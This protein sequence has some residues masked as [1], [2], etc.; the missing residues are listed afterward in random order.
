MSE[1]SSVQDVVIV[2]AGAAGIG[3]A[4]QA[5]AD[6]LR[7]TVLEAAPRIGG[8]A[9]TDPRP[10]GLP[11]DAGCHW[12]HSA[13]V[14]PFTKLADAYGFRYATG[15]PETRLLLDGV[16]VTDRKAEVDAYEEAAYHAALRAGGNGEDVPVA[17]VVDTSSPYYG[18]FAMSIR[19]EWGASPEET[20]TINVSGYDAAYTG[21]DWPVQDG[22]GA[23]VARHA[24]GIPVELST[25][26]TR[27]E[28]GRTPIRVHTL[29]GVLETRAVVVTVS[30]NVL[31]DEV[32][33]FDPPLPHRKLEALR[34]VPLGRAN[35]VGILVDDGRRLGVDGHGGAL[36]WS[37]SD[38]ARGLAFQLRPFGWDFANAYIAGDLC[39]EL[40]RA[41]EAAMVAYALENLR[42]LLGSDIDR[43]VRATAVTRWESE[44]YI[45]G[46][47]AVAKPGHGHDR[48]VIR[49]PLADRVHFAGEAL[50]EA[51]FSTCHGAYLSGMEAVG[52]AV[53]SMRAI[54]SSG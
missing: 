23:L 36:V 46:A 15:S 28:W 1:G 54:V 50:S 49:E 17:V 21:E 42:A 22:Y 26:V 19:A 18:R 20:S 3:A 14:N 39:G 35:K 24:A 7:F 47:Y 11:W 51:W 30:T 45:R 27:I 48:A 41:G 8:R 38:P 32:I 13:S 53:A 43:H 2:G 25:P 16:D 10:F 33:T 44:P 5:T 40:E 34:N 52:E 29:R 37:S 4:K 12:L 6:G 31:A 9:V